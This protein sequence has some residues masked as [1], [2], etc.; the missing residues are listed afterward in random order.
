MLSQQRLGSTGISRPPGPQPLFGIRHAGRTIAARRGP[1]PACYGANVRVGLK[2]WNLP[3][4]MLVGCPDPG[5]YACVDDAD[6]DRSGQFGQC[7]ADRA[8][9]YP[10]PTDRCPSGLIRSPNAATDPGGC[11]PEDEAGSSSSTGVDSTT[12][13]DATTTGEDCDDPQI[14][15]VGLELQPISGAGPGYPLLIELTADD[16]VGALRAHASDLVVSSADGTMLPAEWMLGDEGEPVQ[17]WIK[18]PDPDEQSVQPL[19]IRWDAPPPDPTEVWSDFAFVWH[20]DEASNLDATRAEPFGTLEGS[21]NPAQATEAIVGNG[22]QFDGLDDVLRVDPAPAADSGP[23]TISVWARYDDPSDER[24]EYFSSLG[25][26]SLYPRCYR[27]GEGRVACQVLNGEQ[28]D[29]LGGP[30]HPQGSFRHIVLVRDGDDVQ[31]Y[32]DGRAEGS[33]TSIDGNIGTGREALRIADGQWGP[34]MVTLDELR[35]ADRATPEA[36]VAFD[37]QTHRDPASAVTAASLRCD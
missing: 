3:L 14:V 36:W 9:A 18:L 15:E 34:A 11:V 37:A 35:Y 24:A 19:H 27:N 4:L 25:G 23:F 6:C 17:A 21:P 5:D 13:T 26:D 2:A 10:V 8:C 30:D 20:F 12:T 28:S 31:L 7:L 16:V 33:S 22:F 32:V 1:K 29:N